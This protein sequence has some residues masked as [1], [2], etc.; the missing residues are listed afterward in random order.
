MAR[1]DS[2][3]K[4]SGSVKN[5]DRRVS[6]KQNQPVV[7]E[8]LSEKRPS[9]VYQQQ[10]LQQQQPQQTQVQPPQSQQ[11]TQLPHINSSSNMTQLV[12]SARPASLVIAKGERP[13]IKLV[14]TPSID[15]DGDESPNGT[16]QR[17]HIS[18]SNMNSN[19]NT[20][21]STRDDDDD[22]ES[23]PLVQTNCKETNTNGKT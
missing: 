3:L 21:I 4:H 13:I 9:I 7:V 23:V 19:G 14:R 5:T 17:N 15:D 2:I 22:D 18:M 6:I 20:T 10:Q 11:S 12:S 1:R 16:D 8:Y